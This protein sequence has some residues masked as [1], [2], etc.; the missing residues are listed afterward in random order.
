MVHQ[1]KYHKVLKKIDTNE[2]ALGMQTWTYYHQDLY[3][4]TDTVISDSMHCAEKLLIHTQS[5][6]YDWS[7]QIVQSIQAVQYWRLHL[8]HITTL[9]VTQHILTVTRLAAGLPESVKEPT[10]TSVLVTNLR[11]A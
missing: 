2:K 3:A 9:K 10:E 11:A 6:Q 5:G 8:K 1:V 7:L 4:T